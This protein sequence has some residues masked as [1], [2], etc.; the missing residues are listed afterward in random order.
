MMD[1][2]AQGG[3]IAGFIILFLLV[4]LAYLFLLP[5]TE[6]C[7]IIPDLPECSNLPAGSGTVAGV[8]GAQVTFLS[9]KPGLLVPV[10]D[11]AEY[12]LGTI[13]LFNKEETDIPIRISID[14]I[15]EKSWFSKR[16]I[17]ESFEIPGEAREATIFLTIGEASGMSSI[18][19]EINKKV[20][21]KVGGEGT[22]I[23][24]VPSSMLGRENILT[25]SAST[26]ILPFITSKFKI[27]S[28]IVKEKYGLIQDEV[29][30]NFALPY[31]LADLVSATFKFDA[32][33]YSEDA[34]IVVLNNATI[35][36]EKICSSFSTD[37]TGFL[38]KNNELRFLSEGTFFIHDVKIK[39]KA[40]E[41]DYPT[42]F[43]VLSK[44][45]FQKIKEGRFL[46]ML[47]LGFADR[48]NKKLNVLVNGNAIVINTDK[49]EFQ[50]AV[51]RLLLQGQN[52]VKIIPE[53]VINVGSIDVYSK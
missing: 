12:D 38:Q 11:S 21:A 24:K 36:N 29:Q 49:L 1:K 48:T 15:I 30:R 52:S 27:S 50:T 37:I 40:K 9:E 42:Y 8:T 18:V 14:P 3:V 7:K 26:P 41:S 20:V 31:E 33:C 43:F 17:E 35:A 53:K 46:V 32:D 45:N 19:V 13:N 44:E 10:K 28:I 23:I 22:H 5:Y 47:R 2:K 6:K 34:L 25:L 39:I 4:I 51:S 16:I